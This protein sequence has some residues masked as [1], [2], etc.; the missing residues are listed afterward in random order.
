WGLSLFPYKWLGHVPAYEI[1]A[2]RFL[3]S[4]LATAL[5]VAV[6]GQAGEVKAVLRQ[7]RLRRIIPLSALMIFINATIYVVAIGWDRV[8]EVSF[9][10]F[11]SPLLLVAIGWVF[12]GERLTIAQKISV[13]LSGLACAI[14]G[15]GLDRVPWL[16]FAGAIS[17]TA[18]AFIKKQ[19]PM[20]AVT[21][22]LLECALVSVFSAVVIGTLEWNGTGHFQRSPST[23]AM[24]V[25]TLFFTAVPLVLFAA[26]S[27]RLPLAISGLMQYMSPSLQFILALAVFHEPGG[28]VRLA[29][30]ALIWT[31]L[32]IFT[33]DM[34][35]R[36]QTAGR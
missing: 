9:G 32:I 36:A 24:L 30:F 23:A 33:L 34:V 12:L 22:F 14:M 15:L 25:G 4:G 17:W 13:A 8:L 5:L 19:T 3:W 2:H 28:A 35:R 31:A 6:L 10:Y 7:P 27:V 16:G 18:Y 11:L 29:S 1:N 21:G 26:S 20:P